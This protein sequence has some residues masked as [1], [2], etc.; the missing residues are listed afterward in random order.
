MGAPG[1]LEISRRREIA[2]FFFQADAAK[3]DQRGF[4]KPSFHFFQHHTPG[5][6]MSARPS[7]NIDVNPG[8]PRWDLDQ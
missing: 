2:Q 6:G 7:I 5:R 3:V 8:R 4:L 1:A